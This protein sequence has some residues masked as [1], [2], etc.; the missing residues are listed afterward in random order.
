MFNIHS[1]SNTVTVL[2]GYS[3]LYLDDVGVSEAVAACEDSI[4]GRGDTQGVCDTLW[5]TN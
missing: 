1:R 3:N 2:T 5:T 4:N